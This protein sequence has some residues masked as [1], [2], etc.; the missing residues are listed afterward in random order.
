MIKMTENYRNRLIEQRLKK[1]IVSIKYTDGK[2]TFKAPFTLLD[3]YIDGNLPSNDNTAN[4]TAW[5]IVEEKFIDIP[6]KNVLATVIDGKVTEPEKVIKTAK[7]KIEEEKTIIAN[8]SALSKDNKL[9]Y[10]EDIKA[11]HVAIAD[12]FNITNINYV[13]NQSKTAVDKIKKS[14]KQEMLR[15]RDKSILTIENEITKAGDNSELVADLNSMKTILEDVENE[16][17]NELANKTTFD[18]LINCWPSVLLPAPEEYRT[19]REQW[20]QI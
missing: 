19:L 9:L 17:D 14:M 5:S 20:L 3:E 6:C 2:N 16:I 4:V 8:S 15:C 1:M 10:R 18:E 11:V 7:E 13:I 12:K